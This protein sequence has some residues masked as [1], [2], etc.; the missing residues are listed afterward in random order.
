MPLVEKEHGLSPLRD[1]VSEEISPTTCSIMKDVVMYAGITLSNVE[2]FNKA[3]GIDLSSF[4][5]G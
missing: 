3:G 4:M 5:D 1:L 2:T